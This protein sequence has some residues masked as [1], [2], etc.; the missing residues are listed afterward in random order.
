MDLSYPRPARSS[1]ST[2]LPSLAPVSW[3]EP[4]QCVRWVLLTDP[5]QPRRPRNRCSPHP[6]QLRQPS[7]AWFRPSNL[8][9]VVRVTGYRFTHVR[10]TPGPT[11]RPLVP[12]VVG[13]SGQ[14]ASPPGRWLPWPADQCAPAL[15]S[16]SALSPVDLFSAVDRGSD[17]WGYLVP[18]HTAVLLK[19]P[20]VFR[21]ST[22]RP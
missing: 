16:A 5:S 8:H 7:S 6:P 14:S 4:H 22:R 15:A 1:P 18:L 10:P 11:C 20:S 2:V 9:R 13:P 21:E 3:P 12:L 19:R 17:G